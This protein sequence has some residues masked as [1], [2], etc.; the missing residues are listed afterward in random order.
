MAAATHPA[1]LDVGSTVGG[2]QIVRELG[3]G[4]M[5]VVYEAYDPRR[6][7]KVALKTVQR[8][9][10]AAVYRFKK[11]FRTLADLVHPNLVTLY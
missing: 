3:R 8:L 10:P 9:E 1:F 2:Y 4:G 5:G 6:G 11:E 7:E